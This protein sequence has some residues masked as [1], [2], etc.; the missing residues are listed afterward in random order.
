MTTAVSKNQTDIGPAEPDRMRWWALLPYAAAGTA[1]GVIL[2]KSEVVSWYR[3][4]EMFRFQSFHMYGVLGSAWLTALICLQLLR[5]V[6]ARAAGGEPITIPTKAL[7]KGHRYWMG[8]AIFGVGW[9]FSG[10]CPGPLFALIGSG[11][12]VYSVTALAA[13]AGAWTY[14]YFR[15]QLPH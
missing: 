15:D 11:V 9:A 6:R 7:G 1:L 4:Q 5:R 14:G 10:A 8:G 13:L 3:I 12:A 2:V